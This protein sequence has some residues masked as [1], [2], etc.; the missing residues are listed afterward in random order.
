MKEGFKIIGISI[1]TTN[2][3]NQALT[4][5]GKLWEQFYKDELFDNIPNKITNDVIAIYTDYV[6]NYT[7]A[8][9]AIIGM[10]VSTLAHIPE[11]M[12][13][14]EFKAENFQKY[15]AKGQ[16]PDAVQKTWIDIWQRDQELNR[17]Y[18]YDLE[19]YGER[20]GNGN[21]AEVEIYISSYQS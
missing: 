11:G 10:P 6:S 7:E 19:V 21:D 9:T 2:M 18:T 20:A 13:G 14:R 4:D 3:E 15:V 17:K 12:I 16:M 5:L 1:R 8:Y